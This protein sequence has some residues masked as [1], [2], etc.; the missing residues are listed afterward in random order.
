[1]PVETRLVWRKD[2]AANW[3]SVNPVLFSGEMGYVTDTRIYKIGD[4]VTA[5]N[6][7]PVASG[8]PGPAGPAGP[9][10]PSGAPGGSSYLHTQSSASATWTINHNLGYNPIVALF[11]AGNVE[12]QGT[13]TH[14]S[15]NQTVVSLV[16]A[17]TGTAR[18]I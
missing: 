3:A 11:T 14:T 2:T 18:L 6:A 12:F 1:M 7:L 5:W 8:A 16:S 17:V 4:G 15:V 13:I 9:T 10:G